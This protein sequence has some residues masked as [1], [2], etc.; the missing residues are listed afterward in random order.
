MTATEPDL[1]ITGPT[2]RAL[3]PAHDDAAA[4][5]LVDAVDE[6][7]V[8]RAREIIAEARQNPDAS[9][10]GLYVGEMLQAMYIVAK[11]GLA[12]DVAYL[13]VHR[14]HRRKGHGRMCLHD[15]LLR[16]GRR[17]LTLQTLETE[18][19]FYKKVGFKI[20]SRRTD[21]YGRTVFR[22]GWHAPIP[23]P[24]GAPGEVVC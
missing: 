5:I 13:A 17:P 4:A 15:A 11:Q 8:E 1:V 22:L 19:P 10:Y 9:L 14:D 2:V 6:G 20:V 24:G 12:N 18:L 23:K 7:T 21:E 16:S 3:D